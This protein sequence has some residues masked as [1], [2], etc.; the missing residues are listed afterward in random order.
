MEEKTQMPQNNKLLAHPGLLRHISPVVTFIPDHRLCD[1]P[2][3]TIR[4]V[5]RHFLVTG[6]CGA[7]LLHFCLLCTHLIAQLVHRPQDV[8]GFRLIIQSVYALTLHTKEDN[9]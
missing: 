5:K 8:L 9:T 2:Q 4:Y 1:E 3:Q 7:S 6:L